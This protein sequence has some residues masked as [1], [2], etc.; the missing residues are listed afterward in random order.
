M[1][2]SSDG[3]RLTVVAGHGSCDNGPVVTTL[4]TTGSVVL[5]GDVDVREGSEDAIC[6]KELLARQAT[7]KLDEPLRD[8]VLLDAT[9][10]RPIPFKPLLGPLTTWS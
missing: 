10:G 2:A 3:R 1:E 7:V 9:T 6:T 4:E 8:R 5:I